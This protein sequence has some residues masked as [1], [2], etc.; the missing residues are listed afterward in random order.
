MKYHTPMPTAEALRDV[1]SLCEFAYAHGYH[2]HGYN[3]VEVIEQAMEHAR[4]FVREKWRHLHDCPEIG[5]HHSAVDL[6]R[7]N[8]GLKY[9]LGDLGAQS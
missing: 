2:E 1:K 4:G 3:P 5:S 9:A 6:D 8:C 7:C